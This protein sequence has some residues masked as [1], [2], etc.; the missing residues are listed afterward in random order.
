MTTAWHFPKRQRGLTVVEPL[1]G[2]FFNQDVF[3]DS[4]EKAFVREG[5]Q[6]ALDAQATPEKPVEVRIALMR[7]YTACKWAD[8]RRIFTPDMWGHIQAED[9]GLVSDDVPAGDG[10]K[11]NYL[12]FEDFGTTGLT[13]DIAQFDPRRDEEN[14]FF[15][16]FRAVGSTNKVDKKL[17]KWGVGKYTFWML[18]RVRTV[19]GFTVREAGSP[20]Y[21][22]MGKTILKSHAVGDSLNQE[23]QDGYYGIRENGGD[24]V[25][26]L[27]EADK[28]AVSLFKETFELQRK[29]EPGLSVVVPWIPDEVAN[30]VNPRKYLVDT[31][32]EDYFYPIVAGRLTVNVTVGG[33]VQNINADNI[34]EFAT[35]AKVL[36]LIRLAQMINL[37]ENPIEIRPAS[38]SEPKWSESMFTDADTLKAL[39]DSLRDKED[40]NMR[41]GVKVFPRKGDS[42]PSYFDVALAQVDEDENISDAP[43]F[44][45][46]GIII[47]RVKH[48]VQNNLVALVVAEGDALAHF[49]GDSENPSH[50]EW[51][52]RLLQ[53]KGRYKQA[54]ARALLNFVCS[55]VTNIIRIVAG[56][57]QEEDRG[58]LADI[59]PMPG[60]GRQKPKAKPQ[61][62]QPIQPPISRPSPCRIRQIE[63]GFALTNNPEHI[64]AEGALLTVRTAYLIRRGNPLKRYAE[65][66]FLLQDLSRKF[67]GMDVVTVV[68]NKLQAK[69]TSPDFSLS[70]SGFDKNRDIYVLADVA[71]TQEEYS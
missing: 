2:Q 8:A 61:P 10:E 31:V 30:R 7:N 28:D 67:S 70:V 63:S 36:H 37:S 47:P 42:K 68:G 21:A 6:N 24:G 60:E 33:H 56:A 46:D 40:I 54:E 51:Q 41:V 9:N 50:T 43:C 59:F 14:N 53:E 17:G 5:I 26:P 15:N 3:G 52:H 38:F 12:V 25:L 57:D 23:Y 34:E 35:N 20:E 66:D 45:R 69:I 64:L 13:G 19:F 62:S 39:G 29:D 11:C 18:S 48:P 58:I 44:V 49:L 4:L 27:S 55:S 71:E 1:Q 16:F 32:L 22:L 65:N